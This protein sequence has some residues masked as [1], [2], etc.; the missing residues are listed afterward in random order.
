VSPSPDLSAVLERFHAEPYELESLG[1]Y[2]RWAMPFFVQPANLINPHIDTALQLDVT[3]TRELYERDHAAVPG[4][5]FTAFL[6]WKLLATL[7]RHPAFNLRYAEGS[8]YLLRNP[9]L[10]IPVAIG[11]R[12]RF[13]DFLLDDICGLDFPRFVA[14]Y[15]D[16]VDRAHR[17]HF[18]PIS[19]VEFALSTFIGNLPGL[20]FTALTL[21]AVNHDVTKP[22]FYFGQR[23]TLDGRLLVP[24]AVKMHHSTG[25]LH[26]LDQLVQDFARA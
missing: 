8:W 26:L 5:S 7:D 4:A 16:G 3:Q 23:Y 19:A 6:T 22:F 9:G 12:E 21:H 2:Q 25:D 15:R 20:R 13:C 18:Q 1:H 24:F 14:R 11:G 10:Y 17:G